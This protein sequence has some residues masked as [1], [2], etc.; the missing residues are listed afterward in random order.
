MVDQDYK[1][2]KVI[3]CAHLQ[4]IYNSFCVKRGRAQIT[5]NNYFDIEKWLQKMQI[6]SKEVSESGSPFKELRR[7]N[8]LATPFHQAEEVSDRKESYLLS[9]SNSTTHIPESS[10][11]KNVRR[12]YAIFDKDIAANMF[13]YRIVFEEDDIVPSV[14]DPA[15]S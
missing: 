4:N 9:K 15:T 10:R 8:T 2:N 11:A 6:V 13:G 14:P 5:Q 3:V 7:T 1:K 12:V